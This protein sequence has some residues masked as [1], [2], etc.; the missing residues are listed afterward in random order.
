MI[1]IVVEPPTEP[2]YVL[3]SK[4][5]STSTKGETVKALGGRTALIF[6]LGLLALLVWTSY[7]V[8]SDSGPGAKW[9]DAGATTGNWRGG[10]MRGRP[11]SWTERDELYAVLS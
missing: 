8:F 5:G 7:Q 2:R 4:V 10:E 11:C 1:T 9:A 6:F 3:Y